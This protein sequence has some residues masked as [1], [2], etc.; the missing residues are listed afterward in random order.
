MARQ[1]DL[2]T[3][4]RE[5]RPARRLVLRIC[6]TVAALGAVAYAFFRERHVFV[7][8]T[9]ELTHLRWG[10]VGLALVA[11]LASIV[12]LAEAQRRVL[13]VTGTGAPLW[14][15]ILVTLASNAISMSVPA[16]VAFAEGYYFSR[17][18]EFGASKAQAVWSELASGAIA[19]AALAV[20]ALAG[21]VAAGGA[22]MP[23]VVPVLSIVSAG[24]ITAAVLFR[25]PRLL[26]SAIEWVDR[27]VGRRLG[28]LI[29]RV[30]DRIRDAARSLRGTVPSIATWIAAALLSAV[31]WLLDVA[32][33]GFSFKA[34]GAP[35]PWGV[36]L[37]AFAGGKVVTSLGITPGG[38]GV[39]E[40][41]LVA[42]F[43]AFGAKGAEA[44]AAVLV[45]RGLT[46]V[47]LVGVGWLVAA[48]LATEKQARS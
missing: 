30:T 18:R 10:W 4:K 21:A 44:G 15:M 41:G 31:N 3:Q 48:V 32:C 29:D 46:L 28:T 42:M 37:L 34:V 23:V 1:T 20:V 9:R 25:H 39:V 14:Q 12:P 43:V 6:L 33:L 7:G 45:Y 35:V 24:S 16:G 11:E 8:F 27:L 13:A 38:L 17:Y 22:A 5:G 2:E 36:V 47:G 40:G 19:F 26:V